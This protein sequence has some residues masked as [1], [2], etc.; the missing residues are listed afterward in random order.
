MKRQDLINL[1]EK[2]GWEFKRHGANHD[3]Y[4]KG[5]KTEVIPRHREINE[6]LVQAIIRRSGLK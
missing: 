1:P 4:A 5:N 6:L 3:L 2:N